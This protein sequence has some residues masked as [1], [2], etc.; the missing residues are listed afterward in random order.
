V[1]AHNPA[2]MDAA[3]TLL[4]SLMGASRDGDAAAAV[5]DDGVQTSADGGVVFVSPSSGSRNDPNAPPRGADDGDR[6]RPIDLTHKLSRLNGI[7]LPSLRFTPLCSCD[8]CG[9]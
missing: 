7:H 6:N 5:G 9:A 3:R 1:N 2:M 8:E 4:D